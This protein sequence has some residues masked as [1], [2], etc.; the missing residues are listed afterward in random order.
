MNTNLE[1]ILQKV[2]SVQLGLLRCQL[3]T[4]KLSLHARAGSVENELNCVFSSPEAEV[5]LLSRNVNLIQMDKDDYL[6]I[7]CMVKD[8]VR[9]D[10]AM[11]IS[12]E[13]VKACW[14]TRKSKGSVSWLQEKYMY[15]SALD[16][17]ID[18][19]S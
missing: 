9:K 10:Q 2:S 18:L 6:Y 15:E 3:E 7:A 13:V 12:L 14:F 1:K 19:A 8:E 11:I 5:S 17:G 16:G 4:E